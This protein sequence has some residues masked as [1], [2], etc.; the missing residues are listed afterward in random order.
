MGGDIIGRVWSFRD[1]TEHER[2]EEALRFER[3]LLRTLIDNIPDSIYSKDMFAAKHWPI[4]P[5]CE[6]YEYIQR[7]KY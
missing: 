1:V 6:I 2:A 3:L 5:R 4:L 7:Q